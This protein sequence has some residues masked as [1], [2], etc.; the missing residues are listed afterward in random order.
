MNFERLKG[1][2]PIG[3]GLGISDCELGAVERQ[4]H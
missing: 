3:R 1:R 2:G 4:F